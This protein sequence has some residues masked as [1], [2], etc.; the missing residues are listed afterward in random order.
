MKKRNLKEGEELSE[1]IWQLKI[2]EYIQGYG[3]DI[4]A[5]ILR[6]PGGWIYRFFDLEQHVGFDGKWD[7]NYR[8]SVV[9]VP[10]AQNDTDGNDC[11][12]REVE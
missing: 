5:Q 6:V 9:F 7:E 11:L 4:T 1:V 3:D 8:P 12:K 10:L 2:H